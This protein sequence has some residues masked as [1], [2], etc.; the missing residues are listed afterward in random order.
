MKKYLFIAIASIFIISCNSGNQ[1]NSPEVKSVN[2]ENK[3]TVNNADNRIL[4][5][6][7]GAAVNSEGWIVQRFL[8]DE[9][10]PAAWLNITSNMHM[11]K[12]TINVNLNKA[13]SGTFQLFET[14]MM[15]N[16]H[17][18][19]FPD[20]SNPMDS[21]SFVSGE[22][23]ITELDTIKNILNGTF[24]G[25]AK[26]INDKTVSITEGQLINVKI[27]PGVTNLS[28]EIDAIKN[29]KKGFY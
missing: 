11:D 18:G 6:A 23:N 16:S 8:W 13:T 17:G 10:T 28:E 29:P 12:R 15:K 9:K 2:K 25:V 20:F 21:Y 1:K 7:N 22:F 19:Y 24:N 26:N 27:K 4:F 5:K 3:T 14:G